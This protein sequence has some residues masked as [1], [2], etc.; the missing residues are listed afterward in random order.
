MS[1][2]NAM[3]GISNHVPEIVYGVFVIIVALIMIILS[4]VIGSS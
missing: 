2:I 3:N 4:L 1:E